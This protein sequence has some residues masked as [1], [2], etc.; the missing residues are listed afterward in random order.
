MKIKLL[1]NT[2]NQKGKLF[3]K[4]MS[5]MLDN[6]GYCA[7]QTNVR[8]TGIELDIKAKH[9]VTDQPITCECKAYNSPLSGDHLSKFY[10]VYTSEYNKNKKL[11]GLMFSASGF[12]GSLKEYYNNFPNKVKERFKIFSGEDIYKNL[13]ESRTIAP[14]ETAINTLNNKIKYEVKDIYL[15]V[16]DLGEFWIAKFAIENKYSHFSILAANCTRELQRFEFEQIQQLSDDL[17]KLKPLNLRIKAKVIVNLFNTLKSNVTKIAEEI[18]EYE[19]DIQIAL[20]ALKK[21]KIVAI[22]KTE[23]KIVQEIEAF[24]SLSLMFLVIIISYFEGR[25]LPIST[26]LR[27]IPISNPQL[28]PRTMSAIA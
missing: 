16:C 4:F 27:N 11:I 13:V 18:Q 23:I 22:S 20:E 17:K 19:E 14:K 24:V 26:T 25:Q 1:A 8:K 3:E 12:N 7:F 10:G 9:K 5:K 6:L 15:A 21:E 2:A 28:G